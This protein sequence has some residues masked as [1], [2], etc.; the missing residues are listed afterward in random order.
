MDFHYD[1]LLK[2][3]Q[4]KETKW[5]EIQQKSYWYRQQQTVLET[6]KRDATSLKKT[7]QEIQIPAE[8]AEDLAEKQRLETLIA[9]LSN[10]KRRQAQQKLDAWLDEHEGPNWKIYETQLKKKGGLETELKQVEDQIKGFAG[11][12]GNVDR[13]ISILKEAA[14]LDADCKLTPK[15]ILATEFN[16]G[17]SLLCTE[18]FGRTLHKDLTGEELVATLACFMEEKDKDDGPTLQDLAVPKT[19]K[20]A[21]TSIGGITEEC[22]GLEDAEGLHSPTGYWSL[23]LT[24]VEP[25]WRWIQGDSAAAICNVYGLFEG[26]FVRAVLRV[27]NMVDEWTSVATLAQDLETLEKLQDVKQKLIR[28]I[29]VPDSLYLHL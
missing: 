17:H 12:T 9:T 1:F 25:I 29:L 15:G 6:Y 11:N 5:L 24:W 20:D 19:V 3:F 22:M 8:V 26:N 18:F 4:S 28:E 23:S 16:E 7:I 10:A 2:C 21:L 14:Y 27:A 13:W